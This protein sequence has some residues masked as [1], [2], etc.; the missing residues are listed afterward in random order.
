MC[1][2]CASSK[3]P[4][5]W[6]MKQYVDLAMEHRLLQLHVVV[7]H[8]L[9]KL[10]ATNER[11]LSMIFPILDYVNCYSDQSEY[12]MEL[13][14]HRVRWNLHIVAQAILVK[15]NQITM[16]LHRCFANCW[17]NHHGILQSKHLCRM[18]DACDGEFWNLKKEFGLIKNICKKMFFKINLTFEV[19]W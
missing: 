6:V 18:F 1:N 11:M 16:N 13:M 7:I 5:E 8:H 9:R 12:G 19:S 3:Y 2:V 10:V 4:G 17:W 14:D 15:L